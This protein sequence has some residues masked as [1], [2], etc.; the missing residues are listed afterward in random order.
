L[1]RDVDPQNAKATFENGIL[2]I[3][4]QPTSPIGTTKV[5]IEAK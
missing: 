1:P 4:L 5:P 3:T 2:R